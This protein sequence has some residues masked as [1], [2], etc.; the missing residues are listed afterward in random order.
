MAEFTRSASIEV[1]DQINRETIAN[2]LETG[3]L[4]QLTVS[5]LA[6][7][8][9]MVTSQSEPP[10]NPLHNQWWWDQTQQLMRVYDSGTSLWLAIGPDRKDVPMINWTGGTSPRG[11]GVTPMLGSAAERRVVHPDNTIGG[12]HAGIHTE[13]MIGTWA[14]TV[15]SGAWGAVSFI[16]FVWAKLDPNAGFP[17]ASPNDWLHFHSFNDDGSFLSIGQGDPTDDCPVIAAQQ[18]ARGGTGLAAWVG[19]R[20]G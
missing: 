4:S 1:G 17:E 5:D 16:G 7:G 19:F 18:I 2:L 8:V 20:K 6:S 11:A 10:T 14:D 12:G 9:I 13:H 15:A 3:L